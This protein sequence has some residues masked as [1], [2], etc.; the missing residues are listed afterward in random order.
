M[1]YLYKTDFNLTDV[2]R[3]F[4][5]ARKYLVSDNMTPFL[6]EDNRSNGCEDKILHIEW[7][8]TDINKGHVDLV[9]SEPL[10]EEQLLKVS[11]FISGQNSDGLGEGFEQQE[12]A[13]SF[14]WAYNSY[15][16]GKP[17]PFD[18]NSLKEEYST[19]QTKFEI[20]AYS[21][22]ENIDRMEFMYSRNDYKYD[23]HEDERV[24]E[25]FDELCAGKIS[26]YIDEAN[27]YIKDCMDSLN[28]LNDEPV[29]I[30]SSFDLKACIN[31][32]DFVLANMPK[33]E[34]HFEK[35]RNLSK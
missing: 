1:A 31:R 29:N 12:F 23:Y 21:I 28:L 24:K 30:N 6:L 34:E 32:A 10:T 8:L 9:T 16:F 18:E 7:L 17:E 27:K 11:N 33:I 19:Y 22:A 5:E 14:D 35:H 20:T 13:S 4:E 3:D 15:S 25:I 2:V 26:K